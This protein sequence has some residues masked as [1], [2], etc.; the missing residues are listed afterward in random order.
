MLTYDK[1]LC[2]YHSVR[3]P[4]ES[5]LTTLSLY[6]SRL[7]AKTTFHPEGDY[8]SKGD[9]KILME[10]VAELRKSDQQNK[11]RIAD[12]EQANREQKVELQECKT[13]CEELERENQE[14][15][16]QLEQRGTINIKPWKVTVLKSVCIVL[17]VEKSQLGLE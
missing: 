3:S 15:R 14:L 8:A 10:S 9:L 5:S 1:F 11:K 7:E 12:L 17:G 6:E 2:L 13:K 16:N 4:Q